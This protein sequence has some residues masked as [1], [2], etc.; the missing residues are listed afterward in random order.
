MSTTAPAL[1]ELP[2]LLVSGAM[3]E[4]V[5][6]FG[7]RVQV[8]VESV[9]GAGVDVACPDGALVPGM[10]VTVRVATGAAVAFVQLGVERIESTGAWAHARLRASA[11]LSVDGERR[12]SRCRYAGTVWL[13]G[14]RAGAAEGEVVDLSAVGIRFRTASRLDA[15]DEL[16]LALEVP[17]QQPIAMRAQ[18]LRMRPLDDGRNEIA[19]EVTALSGDDWARLERL[20]S[21]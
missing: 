5:T 3:L 6:A 1:P 11:V 2:E 4:A 7:R 20:L 12:F 14:R 17:G 10:P 16:E 9:D 15:D 21:S 13:G 8:R 18:I 19:A